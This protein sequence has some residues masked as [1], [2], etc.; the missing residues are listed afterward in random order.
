M[1][2]DEITAGIFTVGVIYNLL[3]KLSVCMD[4]LFHDAKGVQEGTTC[5][6]EAELCILMQ[7]GRRR[8]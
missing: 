1:G 4:G 5:V 8:K 2:N 6:F 3:Q 7:I